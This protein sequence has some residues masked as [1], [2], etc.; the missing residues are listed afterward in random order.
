MLRDYVSQPLDYI[1]TTHYYLYL[2][3][4][5]PIIASLDHAWPKFKFESYS[6]FLVGLELMRYQ[7][8]RFSAQNIIIG[9][10]QK[11]RNVYLDVTDRLT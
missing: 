2:T 7:K 8:H 3:A 1:P 9:T 6:S 4:K 10:V 5:L 11:I